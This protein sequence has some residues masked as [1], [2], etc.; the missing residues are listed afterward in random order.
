MD[1][2]ELNTN[3][4]IPLGVFFFICDP[5]Y[6][7]LAL[8]V[9]QHKDD[10]E[11][12]LW[13]FMVGLMPEC[14]ALGGVRIQIIDTYNE[15]SKAIWLHRQ[16]QRFE[17]YKRLDAPPVPQFVYR[18]PS[19]NNVSIS[20]PE[21][22]DFI[23]CLNI[24]ND[25]I[26]YTFTLQAELLF[27]PHIDYRTI[28]I[29]LAHD[30][31]NKMIEYNEGLLL[32]NTIKVSSHFKINVK[33]CKNMLVRAMWESEVDLMSMTNDKDLSYYGVEILSF[34]IHKDLPYGF[35]SMLV[36]DLYI[37]ESELNVEY[38]TKHFYS[39]SHDDFMKENY[40]V[41]D[42]YI[43]SL[44]DFCPFEL[45]HTD[46]CP[47]FYKV[48]F[49][50]LTQKYK[51]YSMYIADYYIEQY[52]K[53]SVRDYVDEW[54]DNNSSK[55]E[56]IAAENNGKGKWNTCHEYYLEEAANFVVLSAATPPEKMRFGKDGIDFEKN[57]R[58]ATY[59]Y[60]PLKGFPFLC[61]VYCLYFFSDKYKCDFEKKEK[62]FAYMQC[63]YKTHFYKFINTFS[64]LRNSESHAHYD[65]FIYNETS[66]NGCD[67]IARE[68]ESTT[69][70]DGLLQYP[71][72][73]ANR[74]RD[75][76]IQL[77]C[78]L[79]RGTTSSKPKDI[80]RPLRAALDAG[81]IRRPTWT[82]FINV[83]GKILKSKSSLDYLKP[84]N[85]TYSNDTPYSVM[86]EQ[87]SSLIV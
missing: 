39:E 46:G 30:F 8:E 31:S 69:I 28:A 48:N 81:A 21:L 1:N 26:G 82:E 67:E 83:F 75:K 11:I 84:D 76:V 68:A 78:D 74:N 62:L 61:M 42:A 41:E 85:D 80:I 5:R 22:S 12:E 72:V 18:I 73:I 23:P 14:K 40:I 77:L 16:I 54:I 32:K 3:I 35:A 15:W 10:L 56:L 57:G 64:T 13:K 66:G 43:S 71:F 49:N 36:S 6:P 59:A 45:R 60:Y 27:S 52:I 2:L 24:D 20:H 87:F 4:N 33:Q 7:Q 37:D 17:E 63:N 79:V 19:L 53:S 50:N 65:R 34:S 44:S 86:K 70:Q 38:D 55:D 47:I 25:A 51:L 58:S 29:T 9:I